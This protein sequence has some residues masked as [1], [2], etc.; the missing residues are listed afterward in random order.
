MV[1]ENFGVHFTE[2]EM[3]ALQSSDDIVASV[4]TNHAS[5]H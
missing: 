1:E 4:E 2:E 3:A 5:Q